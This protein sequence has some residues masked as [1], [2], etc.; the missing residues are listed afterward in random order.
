[1]DLAFSPKDHNSDTSCCK[2]MAFGNVYLESLLAPRVETHNS[3][4][5]DAIIDCVEVVFWGAVVFLVL[6][7]NLRACNGMSCYL[8]WGTGYCFEVS[9]DCIDACRIFRNLEYRLALG[10]NTA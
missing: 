7:E 4:K 8:S 9:A 2:H 10:K 5:A 6:Q 3:Y 1:M